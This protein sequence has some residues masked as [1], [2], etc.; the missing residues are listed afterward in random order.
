MGLISY[1][2]FVISHETPLNSNKSPIPWWLNPHMIGFP[3]FPKCSSAMFISTSFDA[4]ASHSSMPWPRPKT[5]RRQRPGSL[6]ELLIFFETSG[7]IL[8]KFGFWMILDDPSPNFSESFRYIVAF[9]LILSFVW[10]KRIGAFRSFQIGNMGSLGRDSFESNVAWSSQWWKAVQSCLE[11]CRREGS[12]TLL[13]SKAPDFRLPNLITVAIALTNSD[14]LQNY[15]LCALWL[16]LCCHPE[17]SDT[18]GLQRNVRK[19]MFTSGRSVQD[20]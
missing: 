12:T 11:A 5:C 6:D 15:H 19:Q 18:F 16:C 10:E 3:T 14:S 17:S 2:W 13:A 9:P 20:F 1:C 4:T 7:S 8:K